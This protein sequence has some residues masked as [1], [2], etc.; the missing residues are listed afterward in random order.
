MILTPAL[1]ATSGKLIKHGAH[2]DRLKPLTKLGIS[3]KVGSKRRI[4]FQ[5]K[6]VAPGPV[7]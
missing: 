3:M 6:A 5:I 2:F 4:S 1:D 7:E